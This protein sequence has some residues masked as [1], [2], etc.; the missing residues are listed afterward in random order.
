MRILR[1]TLLFALVPILGA[2]QSAELVYTPG[3]VKDAL[4]LKDSLKITIVHPFDALTLVGASPQQKNAYK[5]KVNGVTALVIIGE[6]ALKSV[7]DIEFPAPV[8]LVNAAGPTAARGRVIRIFDGSGKVP[9]GTVPVRS[10]ADVR[11]LIAVGREILLQG[12][13]VDII[14]QAVLV[15]LR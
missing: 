11:G 2:A 7:A 1:L 4:A 12:R 15:A 6:D 5:D 13:P 14:V 3:V 9:P 8:V 10:T